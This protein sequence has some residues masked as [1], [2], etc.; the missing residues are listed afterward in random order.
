MLIYHVQYFDDTIFRISRDVSN[1]ILLRVRC[2]RLAQHHIPYSLPY[3]P[4][5]LR[6]SSSLLSPPPLYAPLLPLD[7][8]HGPFPPQPR[9]HQ[10]EA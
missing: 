7:R 10:S 2:L 5:Q 6:E 8:R 9:R 1:N 4:R 3:E